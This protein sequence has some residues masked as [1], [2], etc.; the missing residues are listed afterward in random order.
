M[1]TVA[2][3]KLDELIDQEVRCFEVE[4]IKLAMVRLGAEVYCVADRCSH[5]DF[6]LSQ[7]EV[8]AEEHEIECARH[9]ASF[10]LRTG[11]PCSFPA[12][13]PV[14]VYEATVRDGLVEVK[15]P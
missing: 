4:G 10:D 8:M 5:E 11:Q 14:A 12:T 13:E 6:P 1:N 9:G 3:C 15:L 7:G 2:L